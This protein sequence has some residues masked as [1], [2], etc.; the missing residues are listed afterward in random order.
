MAGFLA[1]I[2][3]F[4][5]MEGFNCIFPYYDENPITASIYGGYHENIGCFCKWEKEDFIYNAET[6]KWELAPDASRKR[7]KKHKGRKRGGSGLR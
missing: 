4:F 1:T 7:N 3:F 2:G 5:I 6:D